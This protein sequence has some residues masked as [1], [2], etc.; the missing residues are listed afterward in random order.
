MPEL[1]EVEITCR[2]IIPYALSQQFTKVIVRRRQLRWPICVNLA[3]ILEN[4]IIEKISRRG[5]YILFTCTKGTLIVHL[6]MSGKLS[7]VLS[8]V[9]AKKH[10]HVDFILNN[11]YVIRYTDPR[12]FGSV[13]W[14]TED[15]NQH[16]LL[17]HL[18]VEPLTKDF[19]GQFLFSAASKKKTPIKSMLMDASIVVGI[20]N[21]YANEA[22]FTAGIIPNRAANTIDLEEYTTLAKHIKQIL[23]KAII[24]GGT[25]LKD[26]FNVEGKPGYF[27]QN[28][29]VYGRAGEFCYKCHTILKE[30]RLNQRTTVFCPKCQH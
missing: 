18:G 19:S 5:K 16:K 27:S 21:I 24:K 1:P 22:L 3:Q 17:S 9:L 29:M 23:K 14:T 15:P 6:G 2:S 10:D 13:I 25:T 12:R 26:F 11:G 30:I 28:L 4:Q 8:D 7:V 20:G